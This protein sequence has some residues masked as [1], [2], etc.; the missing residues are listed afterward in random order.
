MKPT[1][2]QLNQLIYHDRLQVSDA[3]VW[4]H[5]DRLDRGPKVAELYK[6]GWAK[7]IVMSGNNVL[8]GKIRPG[9][10]NITLGEMKAWLIRHGVKSRDILVDSKSFNT[11]DQGINIINLAKKHNWKSIIVVG[12]WPYYQFRVFLTF[13][14]A[15]EVL[16]Y[17]GR[18]INRFAVIPGNKKPGG[19]DMASNKLQKTEEQ[20]LIKYQNDLV[21]IKKGIDYLEAKSPRLNLR[22]A[23][24]SDAKFLWQLRNDPEVR[25]NSFSQEI[26][27]WPK[28]L[29]WLKK[30]LKNS[31][32]FL[33]I[34]QDS[35]GSAVG[36]VR[37][38]Q[39]GD[40][41]EIS[42]AIHKKV[43]SKGYGVP[44]IQIACESFFLKHKNVKTIIAEVKPENEASLKVFTRAGFK[45]KQKNN[46]VLE[47]FYK[48][49]PYA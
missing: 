42:V 20:K 10:N 2:K 33:Y 23:K 36:Q 39:Q 30:V 4:L 17:R 40:S 41:A 47:L 24:I 19:R 29:E 27:K 48:K 38:D 1:V 25:Q 12:S 44:A 3:A 15:A 16:G 31:Q 37:F 7:K 28:H 21:N 13:L 5:G 49:Q 32:R 35:K 9:E 8:L 43:R 11:K 14:K 34:L 18:V 46:K 45:I 22:K 26:I 6:K